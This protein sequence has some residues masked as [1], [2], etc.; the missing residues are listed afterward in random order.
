MR[1]ICVTGAHSYIGTSFRGYLERWP[2]TYRTEA[3]SMRDGR[4]RG[5]DFGRY[6]AVV[7]TVGLAH[8]RETAENAPQYRAVCRDLAVAAAEKA[9]DAGV[10]QFVF[11][12]SMSVY[13]LE[14]GEIGPEREPRPR[15]AYGRAK[16]EAEEA[17]RAL[18]TEAFRVAV[19]RPP[20]VY[21]PGCPGNYR[22]LERLAAVL[23]VCPDY[24][25]RRSAISIERLCAFMKETVDGGW[26]GT[27][28][29]QDPEYLCTCREIRRLAEARG[30]H[31]P[32]VRALDFVPAVLRRTTARGRKA[33][34]D[35]VYLDEGQRGDAGV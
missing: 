8:V 20:M 28:R 4:W 7:H 9:R 11:L 31:L 10:G 27:F 35:L 16:L 19:L 15:S 6:D 33:F 32:V 25:N 34:G 23:P 5:E 24:R 18:E 26:R 29:P 22:A 13:G 12:S 2:E 21:G 14:E 17:L 3:V 1:R 30:R